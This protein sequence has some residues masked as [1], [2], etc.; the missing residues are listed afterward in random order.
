MTTSILLCYDRSPGARHAIET[1]AAL[2]PG[3]TAVVLNVWTPISVLVSPYGA[4]VTSRDDDDKLAEAARALA[5]HGAELAI[6]AG[7][8]A[9]AD[10]VP[11]TARGTA[12]AIL[13]AAEQMHAGMIALGARGLSP[14]RSLLLGS[15]SHAVVQHAHRPVLVV[16]SAESHAVAHT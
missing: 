2:F 1:A 6:S 16:P 3:S 10:A 13:E 9:S 5:Q 4:I 8:D 12:D 7:L 14:L 15:V 11:A